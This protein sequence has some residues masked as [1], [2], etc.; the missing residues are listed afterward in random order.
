MIERAQPASQNDGQKSRPLLAR[1]AVHAGKAV[2]QDPDLLAFV[3]SVDRRQ[4]ADAG[5]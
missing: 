4:R 3:R 2:R 1:G 5:G